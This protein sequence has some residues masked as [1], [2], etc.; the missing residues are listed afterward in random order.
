VYY[1]INDEQMALTNIDVSVWATIP[2]RH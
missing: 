1:S 2:F